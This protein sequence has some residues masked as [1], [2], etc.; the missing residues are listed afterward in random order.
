AITRRVRAPVRVAHAAPSP[1]GLAF[2]VVDPEIAPMIR[3]VIRGAVH[4]RALEDSEPRL[5]R[6]R[7]LS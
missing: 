6:F 1:I 4:R 3:A 5:E 7:L 2:T